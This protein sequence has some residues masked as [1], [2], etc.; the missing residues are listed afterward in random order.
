[1]KDNKKRQLISLCIGMAVSVGIVICSF[2]LFFQRLRTHESNDAIKHLKD[3]SRYSS[4][5]IETKFRSLQDS[6][7]T[8]ATMLAETENPSDSEVYERIG[9]GIEASVFAGVAVTTR[10]GA[11][12]YTK[13]TFFQDRDAEFFRKYR[14]DTFNISGVIRSSR[15][16]EEL[17]MLVSPIYRNGHQRGMIYAAYPIN[18]LEQ[19]VGDS[20]Y[21]AASYIQIVDEDGDYILST[22]HP[23]SFNEDDNLWDEITKYEF[24]QEYL[25]EREFAERMSAKSDGVVRISFQGDS[26]LS[27]FT[28]MDIADWSMFVTIPTEEVETSFSSIEHLVIMLSLLVLISIILAAVFIMRYIRYSMRELIQSAERLYASEE[29]FRIAFAKTK[30]QIYLYDIQTKTITFNIRSELIASIPEVLHVPDDIRKLGIVHPDSMEGLLQAFERIAREENTECTILIETAEAGYR[31]M[32]VTMTNIFTDMGARVRTVGVMEDITELKMKEEQ[33]Q[34]LKQEA[35]K[36]ALTGLYNR[37]YMEREVERCLARSRNSR[38]L[39]AFMMI[40]LDNF[41]TINDRFGHD[42]GDDVLRD[43]AGKMRR[44]FRGTDVISRFGGDEFVVLMKEVDNLDIIKRRAQS[45]VDQLRCDYEKN[46]E[47]IRISASVG[48]S[49][50]YSDGS[51]FAELYKKAD[52]A[53]YRVKKNGKSGSAV[54]D[55][56]DGESFDA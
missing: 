52:M 7:S 26:R 19:I 46:G 36:D 48:V 42:Y 29:T 54:Y 13:G 50:F 41:K 32:R 18:N 15:V 27:Y 21:D 10:E 8:L 40:D 5:A 55:A 47:K 35:E 20:L 31:W 11:P 33:S 51:T 3:I 45:L 12:L 14:R 22:S 16:D 23:M 6:M 2:L 43:V 4:V 17:L 28:H 30:N 24:D 34:Q 25:S 37:K 44:L 53:L 38:S 56:F 9:N 49:V 39:Q 1:M